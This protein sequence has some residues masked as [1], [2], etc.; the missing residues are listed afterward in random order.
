MDFRNTRLATM[1]KMDEEF[2]WSRRL[3]Y[4][5]P[6]ELWKFASTVSHLVNQIIRFMLTGKIPH[7]ISFT[8]QTP[9]Q[10]VQLIS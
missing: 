6:I 7:I 2:P 9:C 3:Q 1:V 8:N 4:K 10:L 5:L